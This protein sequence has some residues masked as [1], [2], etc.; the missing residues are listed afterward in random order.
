[1]SYYFD[2]IIHKKYIIVF[3]FTILFYFFYAYAVECYKI[4]LTFFSR[5]YFEFI[6]NLMSAN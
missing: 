2:Y 6:K 3:V 1:M 5:Q 4:A